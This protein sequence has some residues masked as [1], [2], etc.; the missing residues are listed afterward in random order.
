MIPEQVLDGRV[1]GTRLEP[2]G[3]TVGDF[4][5]VGHLINSKTG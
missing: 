3:E 5:I 4:A 2:H 1:W